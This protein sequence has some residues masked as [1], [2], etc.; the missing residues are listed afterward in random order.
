METFQGLFE[1]QEKIG[2][3][4]KALVELSSA[5]GLLDNNQKAYIQNLALTYG[6]DSKT[7]NFNVS[8][9][10]ATQA[11]NAF[12]E[13]KSKMS[14]LQDLI[15]V[16]YLDGKLTES[17]RDLVISTGEKLNVLPQK[18]NALLELNAEYLDI[19]KRLGD[20]IMLEEVTVEA[21]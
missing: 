14:L 15:S 8:E 4:I 12:T 16:L 1:S 21:S 5:S 19:T 7:I 9:S 10:E 20:L 18:V 17:E 3:H 6:V 2:E 11:L 13:H